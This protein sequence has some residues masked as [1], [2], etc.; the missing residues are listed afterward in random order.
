M[1]AFAKSV[2]DAERRLAKYKASASLE[3]TLNQQSLEHNANI[4]S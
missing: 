3:K 4:D 2:E 1:N